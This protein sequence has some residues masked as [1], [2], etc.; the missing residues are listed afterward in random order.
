MQHTPDNPGGAR[1]LLAQ[2]NAHV[3]EYARELLGTCGAVQAV[4]DAAAALAFAR[5][6][7]PDLIVADARLPG[8]DPAELL[9]QLRADPRLRATPILLL[10]S[11]AGDLPD[12]A[13]PGDIRPT[14]STGSSSRSALR[15]CWRGWGRAWPG[16]H[17]KPAGPRSRSQRSLPGSRTL[18]L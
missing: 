9:R 16:G 6:E 3:R 1:I 14:G 4:A 17:G 5:S 2:H 13:A 11:R 15:S 10:A 18:S 12:G 7:P 8:M